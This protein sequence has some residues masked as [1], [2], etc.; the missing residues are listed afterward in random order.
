MSGYVI[1]GLEGRDGLVMVDL[2]AGTASPIAA[3]D[4]DETVLGPAGAARSARTMTGVD[5]AMV[6]ES[7]ADASS[8]RFSVLC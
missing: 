8:Q 2:E 1:L 6:V 4:L 5:F 7:R 3:E